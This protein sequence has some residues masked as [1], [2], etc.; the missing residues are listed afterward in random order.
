M[1]GADGGTA[2]ENAASIPPGPA[3]STSGPVTQQS[4]RSRP[5]RSTATRAPTGALL[6][7]GLPASAQVQAHLHSLHRVRRRLAH[8]LERAVVLACIQQR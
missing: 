2:P 6:G 8:A 7:G 1:P 3:G 4:Q 5:S